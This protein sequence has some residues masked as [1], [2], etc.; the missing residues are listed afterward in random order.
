M[1]TRK[2]ALAC[3]CDIRSRMLSTIARSLEKF[4]KKKT[5]FRGKQ[6]RMILS[7]ASARFSDFS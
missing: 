4:L 5:A 6:N 2:L 7:V 1:M 3:L